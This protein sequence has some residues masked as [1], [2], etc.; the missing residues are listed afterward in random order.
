MS[1]FQFKYKNKNKQL[2]ES[3]LLLGTLVDE[4]GL[5]TLFFFLPIL[6]YGEKFRCAANGTDVTRENGSKLSSNSLTRTYM[7]GHSGQNSGING[8]IYSN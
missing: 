1:T 3:V 4:M 7:V 8:T 6:D 5:T 2:P